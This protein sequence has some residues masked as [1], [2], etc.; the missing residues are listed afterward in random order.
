MHTRSRDSF[1]ATSIEQL[2]NAR[3]LCVDSG[4][5]FTRRIRRLSSFRRSTT[6]GYIS[7]QLHR[8]DGVRS[9]MVS[10]G[11]ESAHYL[12][13]RQN[14]GVSSDRSFNGLCHRDRARA[15]GRRLRHP[16]GFDRDRAFYPAL[17]VVIAS[18]YVLFAVMTGSYAVL[19]E[20]AIMTAFAALAVLGF[21]SSGALLRLSVPLFLWTIIS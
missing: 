12:A 14:D 6:S 5:N 17:L 11:A 4:L 20:S 13:P 18:Y 16:G 10:R 19:V 8:K 21:T 9:G 2:V 15:R 7:A 1:D 3:P